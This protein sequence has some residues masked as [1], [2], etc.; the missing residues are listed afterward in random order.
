ML[1][2]NIGPRDEW[3]APSKDQSAMRI[4][5]NVSHLLGDDTQGD[6]GPGDRDWRDRGV[7]LLFDLCAFEALKAELAKTGGTSVYLPPRQ[8]SF[9]QR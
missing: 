7:R 4:I 6:D 8:R 5:D 9:R 1:E 2:P 3:L